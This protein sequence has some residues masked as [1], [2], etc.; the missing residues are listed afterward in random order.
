MCNVLYTGIEKQTHF[1]KSMI[2][3]KYCTTVLHN[4]NTS[5]KLHKHMFILNAEIC[6]E[7]EY[8]VKYLQMSWHTLENPFQAELLLFKLTN[9]ISA[10]YNTNIKRGN[11]SL[12]KSTFGK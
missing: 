5:C 1:S 10:F 4:L 3:C 2:K 12:K 7:N 6:L 11:L 9:K 8:I